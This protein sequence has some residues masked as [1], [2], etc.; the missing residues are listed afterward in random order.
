MLSA[1]E[2][3]SAVGNLGVVAVSLVAGASIAA[4]WLFARLVDKPRGVAAWSQSKNH[5]PYCS[6]DHC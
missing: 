1:G 2:V 3:K 5:S 4:V 6:V